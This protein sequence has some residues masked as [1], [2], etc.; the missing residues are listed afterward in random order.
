M[1]AFTI[2]GSLALAVIVPQHEISLVGGVMQAFE[3]VFDALGVGWLLVPRRC[4][5]PSAGSPT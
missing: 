5:S 1:T 2:L 3:A 4:S